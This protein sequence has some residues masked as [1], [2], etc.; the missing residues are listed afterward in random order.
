MSQLAEQSPCQR[1]PSPEVKL[2]MVAD[3]SRAVSW[4]KRELTLVN[5]LSA[6][7][8]VGYAYLFV[9][10]ISS[11]W[12]HKDWTTDDALQQVYPFHEVAHPG[13]FAGDIVTDVMKGYLAPLHY[14]LCYGVT[15]LTG[16]PDRKSTRLNSSH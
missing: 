2:E 15:M 8:L 10:S 14:W 3:S 16:D 12:F 6:C 11:F 1:H 5:L 4:W 9:S 13:L 7:L